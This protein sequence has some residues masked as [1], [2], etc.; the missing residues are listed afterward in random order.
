MIVRV[1]K[2]KFH[3]ELEQQ[4]LGVFHH[5]AEKIREFEGCL[6]M[7]LLKVESDQ[8]IFMTISH[9]NSEK[10]LENY[11]HSDL[12]KNTWKSVKALFSG[13][14]EAWTLKIVD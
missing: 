11:R 3:P 12:F 5:S 7:N 2:M 13:P 8:L 14:P 9:W 6:K 4:F 1:V 10:D